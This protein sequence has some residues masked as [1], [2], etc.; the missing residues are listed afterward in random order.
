MIK[1]MRRLMSGIALAAIVIGGPAALLSWGRLDGFAGVRWRDL[2]LVPDDGG[3]LLGLLT[4]AGWVAWAWVTGAIVCEVVGAASGGHWRPRLP[5][6]GWIRPALA[7]LVMTAFGVV[8]TAGGSLA[9][10]VTVPV[11][12]DRLGASAGDAMVA[13]RDLAAAPPATAASVEAARSGRPAVRPYVVR[14]G[15]DLWSLADRFAGAGDRWRLLAD[16]NDTVLIDPRSELV[17]GSLLMVPADSGAGPSDATT[18]DGPSDATT[19]DGP[20]DATTPDDPSHATTPEEPSDATT[21]V[22]PANTVTVRSGDTLWALARSHLGDSLRWPQ[23]YRA[24]EE[25]IQNPDLIF[26]GQVLT[27]P[28][29][30]LPGPS[31]GP[32]GD[33]GA[34]PGAEQAE[35]DAPGQDETGPDATPPPVDL[36]QVAGTLYETWRPAEA[37]APP[38]GSDTGSPS[39][40]DDR[41][42]N[43]QTGNAQ[44]GS[45]QTGSGQSSDGAGDGGTIADGAAD[46]R[47][48]SMVAA[49][50]GSLGAGLAAAFLA[51]LAGYRLVELRGRPLGRALPRISESA[52]RFET[53]LDRRAAELLGRGVAGDEGDDAVGPAAEDGPDPGIGG[54]LDSGLDLAGDAGDDLALDDDGPALTPDDGALASVA[55]GVVVL[56][57]DDDQQEVTVDLVG[58]GSVVILGPPD[59][60]IGLLA[61]MAGQLLTA[62]AAGRP[63]VVLAVP[64]LDWL[65]TLADCPLTP[66]QQ[67]RGL[68]RRRQLRRV[69]APAEPLV[70]F[71][72]ETLLPDAETAVPP[73]GVTLVTLGTPLDAAVVIEVD[74]DKATLR[75]PGLTFD[76]QLVFP[77][78]RRALAEL[79]DAV[80]GADYPPA[81]WWSVPD[82]QGVPMSGDTRND[83][84]GDDRAT[85]NHETP[86]AADEIEE[87]GQV[88][89]GMGP[90]PQRQPHPQLNLIGP[91]EL[92]GATGV[93]PS[94]AAKQCL[95]YCAWLLRYP[96]QTSLTMVRSLMVAEGTRRSNMS[97]LRL[98]L[99]CDD[100][101]EPYLPE[102]YSGRIRLHPGVTS[103]WEQLQLLIAGGVDRASDQGLIDALSLVRGA[104]LAD[105]APGQ[106][107]WAEE[108]RCDMASV[109]RDIGVVICD[110][111]LLRHDVDLA[112]WA[113]CRALVAAPEDDL[114]MAARI[115]TEHMAGNSAEVER[116][117]MHVTREARSM[118]FDLPDDMVT[119]LQE[120]IEGQ[121]RLR[122]AA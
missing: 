90:S 27:L 10:A 5:G 38:G 46:E 71:G 68:L 13:S 49:L 3:L 101:G 36:P 33:N 53:A 2:W 57:L 7:V 15:D 64:S 89:I 18:P 87:I 75:P 95:E 34:P 59:Q 50:L 81:C 78:A 102:A 12:L 41:T 86:A 62:D 61:A 9:R 107:H 60:A 42:G 6:S 73:P 119:L 121:P 103:D 83:A 11:P 91:V 80:T 122:M 17:V 93:A 14:P 39:S 109:I 21:P 65:A 100:A 43:D 40:P 54:E 4:V 23:L 77:P 92:A 20:S 51:G 48:E 88:M 110:R 82:G 108:W 94:R 44:T 19:P 113:A 45:G 25:V 29:V 84:P 69:D 58:A 8:S 112:R 67:A 31:A 85:S 72:D 56:G 55:R 28:G 1:V 63:D 24:N 32:D 111:A 117:A 35:P 76:A 74:E 114:L 47:P 115:R 120:V 118:R 52:Q 106:W 70:V 99:G 26:P 79:V 116:L 16:I 37:A 104:P 22:E 97:R 30:A 98:W 66:P 105:A 96:G